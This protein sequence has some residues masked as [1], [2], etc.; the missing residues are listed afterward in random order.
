M[1]EKKNKSAEQRE[2]TRQ[3]R[4]ENKLWIDPDTDERVILPGFIA[5]HPL[6]GDPRWFPRKKEAAAWR[7][8]LRPAPVGKTGRRLA[9]LVLRAHEALA[10]ADEL[11]REVEECRGE[12]R[13]L[14]ETASKEA[15]RA[16]SAVAEKVF[17]AEQAR[18]QKKARK[19]A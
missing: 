9:R 4:S 1:T 10:E 15:H 12:A 17:D 18:E 11:A 7:R 16:H 5:D 14:I 2:K 8:S 3:I 13:E 6:G 19:A